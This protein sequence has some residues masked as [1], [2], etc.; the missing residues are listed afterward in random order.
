[1]DGRLHPPLVAGEYTGGPVERQPGAAPA[2]SFHRIFAKSVAVYEHFPEKILIKK[3]S[4]KSMCHWSTFDAM[5]VKH[6]GNLAMV[7]R[8][9]THGRTS[10]RG[11]RGIRDV[12]DFYSALPRAARHPCDS[13]ATSCHE[14]VWWHSLRYLALFGTLIPVPVINIGLQ[15]YSRP[16]ITNQQY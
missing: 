9:A 10:T 6:S 5:E 15:C 1:M 11:R 2:I 13:M 7:V 12:L 14:P 16:S 4:L 3:L 8:S